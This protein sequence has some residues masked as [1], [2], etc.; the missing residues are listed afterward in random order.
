MM[1]AC[2]TKQMKACAFFHCSLPYMHHGGKGI[3]TCAPAAENSG[4]AFRAEL[5]RVGVSAPDGGSG[6]LLDV[7][8]GC[9]C[10][11]VC[12]NTTSM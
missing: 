5:G 10:A 8:P 9:M 11:V 4:I 1:A 6:A 2:G 3:Y 12:S 7:L